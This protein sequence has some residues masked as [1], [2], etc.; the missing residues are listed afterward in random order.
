M[1][2]AL[3]IP[4]PS[5]PPDALKA[6]DAARLSAYVAQATA[7]AFAD[8]LTEQR[9]RVAFRAAQ[10]RRLSYDGAVGE[11]AD[12]AGVSFATARRIMEGTWSRA[13]ENRAA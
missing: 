7:E 1:S 8:W 9:V 11:A 13:P 2:E 4:L 5:L 10:A 12:A 6:P 3:T